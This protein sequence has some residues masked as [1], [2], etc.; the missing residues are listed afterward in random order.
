MSHN[1]LLTSMSA[2][3]NERFLR[4][5]SAQ[6]AYGY[7]YCEAMQSMEAS[8]K[9]MLAHFP[10]NEIIVIGAKM[11]NA[12]ADSGEPLRLKDARALYAEDQG[13]L[14]SFELYCS[15]LA[16]FIDELSLE[17]EA[18]EKLLPE[19]ERARIIDFIKSFQEQYSQQETK[20]LNRFFD[21][22]ACSRK[23]YEQFKDA[24]FNTFPEARKDS[25]LYMKWVKNYVYTQLKLSA[26]LEILPVNENVCV[27][28]IPDNKMGKREYWVRD[29]FDIDQDVLDGKNEINIFVSLD[30]DSA[31]D[32]Q[33]LLN[34]L[35]IIVSTPGSNVHLKKI[36]K[37]FE[38]SGKLTGSI[39]DSTAVS[40]STDLVVAAHAF[41]NYSKTDMLVEFWENCGERNERISSLVYA[42]R[43]VDMGISMCNI[44]EVQEGIQRLRKL[45]NDGIAWED[46]GD[47][48]LLFSVIAGSIQADYSTLLEGSGDIPFIELIKW[49]YRHQLYQQ[50][51]TLI[52]SHA[53]V[54]LVTSGIF[55][56]CD[57]EDREEEIT[58][59]FA[60][61]RLELKSY[62]QYKLDKIEHYF[63]KYYDRS[64]VRLSGS[65]GEDRNRVYAAARAQSI[66][67]PDPARISGHTACSN[68]ELVQ[69]VLYAYFHLGDVR[70]KISHADANAMIEQR[71]IVSENDV[72]SAVLLMQE[73]IEYFIMSYENALE[74]VRGKDPRVVRISPDAV[75][76]LADR[77]KRERF[78]AE[79]N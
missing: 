58:K 13:K 32:S 56:Y 55:Y 9:Y 60:L 8:T 28:Y 62:E 23:L 41:L 44:Q 68:I 1:I 38:A 5:Y 52:E 22:L 30:N 7:E 6:N 35:D 50:V 76:N 21:E 63:I 27:R 57:D 64:L 33:L 26:K 17:Q 51:L 3:E 48:G 73:S 2:E 29:I 66:M 46:T 11:S 65:K 74:D 54:N 10:V 53:P 42:A 47:Y 61:Q 69:N 43:R 75:R 4:Y 59:L 37:V 14:T 79:R 70:N 71:L 31:V 39:I 34:L 12:G 25:R 15:R 20:R 19:E 45:L 16:Q 67:N 78:Q 18:C 72:S 24:F 49:A 40:R 77:M 36:Y